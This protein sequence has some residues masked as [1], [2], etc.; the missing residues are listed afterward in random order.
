MVRFKK[1]EIIS[2]LKFTSPKKNTRTMSTN[3]NPGWE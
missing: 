1:L 3:T 2:P